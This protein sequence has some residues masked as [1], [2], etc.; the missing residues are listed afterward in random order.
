MAQGGVDFTLSGVLNPWDHAAG[1]LL[2]QQAGGVAQMLDGRAYDIGIEEGFLLCAPNQETWD[3]L[4][5][6]LAPLTD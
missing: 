6:A 2:C 5:E 1:V 4:A 3:T